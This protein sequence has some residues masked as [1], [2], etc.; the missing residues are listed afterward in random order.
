MYFNYAH[1]APLDDES[2]SRLN[3]WSSFV[4]KNGA[5]RESVRD[6]VIFGAK[7][8]DGSNWH[9]LKRMFDGLGQMVGVPAER[10]ILKPTF[11]E[12]VRACLDCLVAAK[13]KIR[14]V[15]ITDLEHPT[16]RFAVTSYCRIHQ[17][18][19]RVIHLIRNDARN[20]VSIINDVM[21]VEN[22]D[23]VFFT[24]V[25]HITGERLDW[26]SVQ[27]SDDCFV[28]LDAVHS[29]G[30]IPVRHRKNLAI[31]GSGHKWLGGLRGSSILAIC[32]ERGLCDDVW[33]TATELANE[34]FSSIVEV[35]RY[36]EC[37]T[38]SISELPYISLG[39]ALERF[40]GPPTTSDMQSLVK[41]G[42]FLDDRLLPHGFRRLEVI[43]EE[44]YGIYSYLP[45]D[46]CEG[47]IVN[48]LRMDGYHIG[49]A[50]GFTGSL[51]ICVPRTDGLQK[52]ERLT[53]SIAGIVS[54][55]T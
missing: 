46:D 11:S 16:L 51:R 31:L 23:V 38:G 13:G 1:V 17:I 4:L 55:R 3:A 20:Y 30:Q 25:S 18:D 14:S 43:G 28:V 39:F 22:P 8:P 10:V 50:L 54:Q 40:V 27:F 33:L 48:Q 29:I 12:N 45:P 2:I 34:T 36:I 53:N 15:V 9:G 37:E 19:L 7:L 5:D 47:G 21:Q 42:E 49:S 52:I 24:D 35:E 26:T 6:A 44:S 32:D 41:I